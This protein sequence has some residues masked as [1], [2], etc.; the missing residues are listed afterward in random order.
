MRFA[1]ALHTP[2]LTARHHLVGGVSTSRASGRRKTG[3]KLNLGQPAGQF[4]F[5][6]AVH[7]DVTSLL[8]DDDADL[9]DGLGRIW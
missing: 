3:K 9:G 7:H 1:L 2:P 5:R 4:N 8:R 6:V